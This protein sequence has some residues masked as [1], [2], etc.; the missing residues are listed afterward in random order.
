MGSGQWESHESIRARHKLNGRNNC[1]KL[2][3]FMHTVYQRNIELLLVC[4]RNLEKIIQCISTVVSRC[5]YIFLQ[6]CLLSFMKCA[7]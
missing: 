3:M 2:M 7:G 5:L 4:T 6:Y 1:H